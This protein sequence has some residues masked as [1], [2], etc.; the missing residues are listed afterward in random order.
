[1]G[2]GHNRYESGREGEMLRVGFSPRKSNMVL[3]LI[4]KGADSDALRARLGKHKTGG[5]CLYINRLKDVELSVLESMVS[6]SWERARATYGEPDEP[7]Q[8]ARKL[9]ALGLT[10]SMPVGYRITRGASVL[11]AMG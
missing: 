6:E 2:P 11:N 8:N 9:K 1:M 7:G 10:E 3:Y 5:S 4:A